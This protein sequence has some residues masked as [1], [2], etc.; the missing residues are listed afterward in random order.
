MLQKKMRTT[1]CASHMPSLPVGI[2]IKSAWSGEM[3]TWD[4][5]NI[6]Q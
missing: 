1:K 4:L 6:T 3:Q 5:K 2:K